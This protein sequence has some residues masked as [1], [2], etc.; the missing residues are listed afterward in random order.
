MGNHP[1]QPAVV[2][3]LQGAPVSGVFSWRQEAAV[4]AAVDGQQR[5]RDEAGAARRQEDDAADHVL[6]AAGPAQ[7]TAAVSALPD[8]RKGQQ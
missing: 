8:L 7:R 5:A 4:S 6:D 3:V 2:H 1:K